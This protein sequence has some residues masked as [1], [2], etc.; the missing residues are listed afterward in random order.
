MTREQQV[1]EAMLSQTVVSLIVLYFKFNKAQKDIKL[2]GYIT[3]PWLHPQITVQK[4]SNVNRELQ[5]T[6]SELYN[7]TIQ[8]WNA[9]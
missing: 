8:V 1:W 2:F 6:Q 4:I 7:L 3:F 5:S 9:E